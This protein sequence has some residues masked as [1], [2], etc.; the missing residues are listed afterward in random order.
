ML[1]GLSAAFKME[2]PAAYVDRAWSRCHV[3]EVRPLLLELVHQMGAEDA[4]TTDVQRY[5]SMCVL[6]LSEMRVPVRP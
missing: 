5:R 3:I 6:A 2:C 4:D 1:Q